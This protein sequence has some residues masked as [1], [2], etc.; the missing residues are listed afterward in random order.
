ME[1]PLSERSAALG[2]GAASPGLGSAS[3][4]TG[5][6]LAFASSFFIGASFIV[7]KKGLRLAAASS[8]ARASSN[9]FSYLRQPLWWAGFL[10]L[11]LGEAANF[12]A[13]AYAP[14]AVVTPLGAFSILV[15]ALGAQALLNER[16]TVPMAVGCLLI[17]LGAVPLVLHAPPDVPLTSLS[18]VASLAQS[19]SFL[20]FLLTLLCAV[21]ALARWVEPAHGLASPLPAVLI[22]SLVGSLS[23]LLCKA[24]GCALRLVFAGSESL[25][26][27]EVLAL[28]GVLGVCV[29]VQMGYLNKALD[30]FQ[31]GRVTPIY[32]ALFTSLSLV[33]S[34]VLYR[35][36]ERSSW[37]ALATQLC[38]FGTMLV[39]VFFLSSPEAQALSPAGARE[40]SRETA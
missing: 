11:T 34:A 4:R 5:A 32:Y 26:S 15:A 21:G 1:S 33:A 19:P 36:W 24:L 3:P 25:L 14:A 22:C 31:T 35:D 9:G 30:A 13:Y 12:A 10:T 29:T 18:E 16:L 40:E 2:L 8:F 20:L 23:V 38:G 7:K 6:L 17:C 37:E 27:R 39:G 28:A